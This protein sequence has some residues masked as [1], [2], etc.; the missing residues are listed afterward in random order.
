MKRLKRLLVLVMIVLLSCGKS[1]SRI[2]PS[3]GGFIDDS[4]LV[5]INDIR[6]ANA[7]MISLNY[8]REI[9]K[10]LR[11]RINTD[12]CT[13]LLLKESIEDSDRRHQM[14]VKKLKQERNIC[15][16]VSILSILLLV[17]SL[18]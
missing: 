17:L 4:V 16:G 9:N 10:T 1:W 8:E 12:S 2:P 13:I 18:L 15:G 7:K 6:V 3:T 5:S 14:D 11:Q